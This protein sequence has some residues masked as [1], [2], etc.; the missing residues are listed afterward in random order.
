M[1]NSGLVIE[2]QRH[3]LDQT[4]SVSTLLRYAKVIAFKLDLRDALVWIDGE[5]NGYMDKPVESVPPYRV[6]RG[7]VKGL[8]PHYGWRPVQFENAAHA[9]LF[10]AAHLG[11]S[12]GAMEEGLQGDQN[13]S[14]IG[15]QWHPATKQQL[16]SAIS[17]ASDVM[18]ELHR[19]QILGIIDAVR[20]IVLEWAL[21]LEKE[22]N[23]GEGMAFSPDERREAREVSHNYFIQNAGV[24]GNVSDQA[25]VH[26]Q[27]SADIDIDVRLLQDVLGQ[28]RENLS[29]LPKETRDTLE[30]V[31][32]DIDHEVQ[33]GGGNRARLRELAERAIRVCEGASGNVIATGIITMLSRLL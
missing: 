32:D 18:L 14:R 24:I 16:L 4:I 11:Q 25:Q 29:G 12:L 15:F 33:A 3:A 31:L 10:S 6:V 9:Q 28:A 1:P 19:G 26:G 27:Q 13:G 22:G 17:Y 7:E 20:N 23:L 2:L 5:L 21:E 8:N 30:R